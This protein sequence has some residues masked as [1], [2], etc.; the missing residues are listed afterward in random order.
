MNRNKVLDTVSEMPQEFE[1][2][3]LIERLLFIQSVEEGLEQS[4]A[5]NI[6][7]IDEAKNQLSKWLQ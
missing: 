5:G 4:K 2:E 7:S 3:N 1:V 6:L